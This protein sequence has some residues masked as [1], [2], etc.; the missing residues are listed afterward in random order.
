MMRHMLATVGLLALFLLTQVSPA[1]GETP[2]SMPTTEEQAAT[3]ADS[4]P[5]QKRAIRQGAG[6]TG[7]CTCM[8]PAGQCVFRCAR[9]LCLTSGKS[10]Q[11]RLYYATNH[12][13]NWRDGPCFKGRGRSW[14]RRI[15]NDGEVGHDRQRPGHAGF[16]ESEMR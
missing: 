14:T 2:A 13:R 11:R 1:A 12:A 6:E 15:G 16:V 8:R 4:G 9:G 7:Q 5:V 10:L 3:P